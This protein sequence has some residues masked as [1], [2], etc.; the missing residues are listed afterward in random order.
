[1]SPR[2]CF[3]IGATATLIGACGIGTSGLERV[4]P[5]A[6][7]QG[8]EAT[9]APPDA[10]S[11]SADIDAGVTSGNAGGNPSGTAGGPASRDE[12]DAELDVAPRADEAAS[13]SVLSADAATEDGPWVGLV[14]AVGC[15]DRA[16]CAAG[17]VCCVEF[18]DSSL[19]LAVDDGGDL[20]TSCQP[21]CT[22]GTSPLCATDDDCGDAGACFKAPSSSAWGFCTLS[23]ESFLP[24]LPVNDA[25]VP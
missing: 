14:G 23:A 13:L 4:G 17:Y 6:P 20:Q 5:A 16:H 24:S 21:S 9:P 2:K 18:G 8:N 15:P 11:S 19:A 7:D 1:M 12:P 25:A 22:A 3:P 10:A